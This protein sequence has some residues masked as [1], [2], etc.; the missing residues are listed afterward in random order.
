MEWL[1]LEIRFHLNNGKASDSE[2]SLSAA[3]AWM[4]WPTMSQQAFRQHLNRHWW[5]S[6]SWCLH[7]TPA[8][9]SQHSRGGL[10]CGAEI[11]R[12]SSSVNARL[13]LSI[14]LETWALAIWICSSCFKARM[15]NKVL[16]EDPQQKHPILSWAGA[17]QHTRW[18]MF[19]KLNSLFGEAV[20]YCSLLRSLNR[21]V[22]WSNAFQEGAVFIYFAPTFVPDGLEISTGD[23]LITNLTH[24]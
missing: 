24:V 8:L 2:I 21:A 11:R 14:A 12:P 4:K 23:L 17:A 20:F 9:L 13:G 1:K 16:Y 5:T 6:A 10:G 18:F 3:F 15:L 19:M 22:G 7:G